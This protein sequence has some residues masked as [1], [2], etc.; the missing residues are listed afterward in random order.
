MK[1]RGRSNSDLLDD[2]NKENNA[3][4]VGKAEDPDQ[5]VDNMEDDFNEAPLHDGDQNMPGDFEEAHLDNGD[6]NMPGDFEEA[7]LD[8]G[9]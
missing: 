7:P 8:N 1:Y 9:D 5:A 2:I 6:Q 3:E 4:N